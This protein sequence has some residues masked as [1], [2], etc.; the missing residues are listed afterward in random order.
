[1]AF[2]GRERELSRLADALQR[3]ADGRHGRV[4]LT[5][6]AGIGVTRLLDELTH[7]IAGVPGIVVARGAALESCAGEA[8]Q[9]LG[10]ALASALA[11]LEDDRVREVVGRAGHDLGLVLRE[12]ATRLDAL[13]IDRSPPALSAPDQIGSRVQEA[14]LGALERLAGD[15]IVL[16]ALEDLHR[17]DP[18]TRAFIRSLLRIS[19]PLP[20]CLVLTYQ[21]DELHRRHPAR[22]LARA[23]QA[24]PTIEHLAVG[25]LDSVSM[26][27]LVGSLQ[28]DR[29][30][31]DLLAAV[32][33]GSGGNPLMATQL[34]AA[35]GSLEGV[36]LSDP[37]EQVVAARIEALPGGPRRVI[38]LLG[39]ARQPIPRA[40]V[41][42]L[43][44]PD[45]R[46]TPAA[47]T[48]A[49]A[50]GMVVE[51]DGALSIAHD[52][53]AEAIED[54]EL[55]N[56]RAGVHAALALASADH[57]AR[58]AC[59]WRA[60]SRTAEARDAHLAAAD[61][62]E[63]LDPG[64]TTLLHLQRV[65][66]LSGDPALG[67]GPDLGDLL[68]RAARA[69]AATGSF[70]RAAGLMRRAVEASVVR[71][72]RPA[73]A[74][75]PDRRVAITPRA[76][77]PRDDAQRLMV[78]AMLE[79]VGRLQWAGGDL[80]GALRSMEQALSTMPAAPSRERA[81]A[82]ASLAQHLM[83]A[84]SFPESARRAEEAIEA[85]RQTGPTALA[86]L[87]HATCTLG[88]DVAYQGELA[89]G[90]AL[91]AEAAR[92]AREAG[93]LDD[94]MRAAA[95]RTTLLDLD[96]RREE[97]LAVVEEGIAE[98]E[99]GG[100]AGTFGAFLRG[101]AADI[102]Y[103]LGRWAESEAECR[104]GME[105]QPAGVA[106][107]S[108]TLY[109]GL[110]LVESRAD[111]EASSLV[112][113]TLLQLDTVPAGQW[114][115]LVQRAAV[116]LALWR[117]NLADAVRVA[118]REWPRV[119]ETEDAVQIALGASTCLEAAAAATEH[120]RAER[121]IGLVS[122][123]TELADL[124]MADAERLV[125]AGDLPP[126][127]G[128]RVEAEIHLATAGAHRARMRG[129]PSPAAWDRLA[130]AWTDR[131]MPYPAA[132]ARWWQVLALL[133]RNGPR[134]EAR[135][136]MAE[137]WR[138]AAALPA[139]PLL[140]TLSDLATRARLPLPEDPARV[141]ELLSLPES[142]PTVL[143]TGSGRRTI[144]SGGRRAVAIPVE[145]ATLL[146]AR[147]DADPDEPALP[148]PYEQATAATD[149]ITDALSVR[150]HMDE[151][152]A[153]SLGLTPR[154]MEVLRIIC[155][156]R[157]DREIS[158][159]LYIS[160]RT[161]HVHVRRV[162]SKLGVSTRTQAAALA[163]RQGIVPIAVGPAVGVP[164]GD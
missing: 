57:P 68:R 115:A 89:R 125:R 55:P 121:D 35:E 96:S 43:N 74:T 92:V 101:N 49:V 76:H 97:A 37:F 154:E 79:E 139:R 100:L 109:L 118:G 93:R 71:G 81:Q 131:R 162:L 164:A 12:G 40:T 159:R 16:L 130:R 66:E 105:W 119:L 13:A 11:T 145:R 142:R 155:E 9:A 77:G 63:R 45:G 15:G 114:S 33:E 84:G 129:R 24:D 62:S 29:P 91:L 46:I 42:G 138:L 151:S 113:Q 134:E 124:V 120:G 21:P 135:D 152:R 140:R 31:G 51:R 26:G 47:I 22:E 8:Y 56:E 34:V 88:V 25:P 146:V 14:V 136:A 41:L 112:G 50:S 102:L 106:W 90:L 5:G 94:L 122:A 158:E 117:G 111:D 6:P 4:V 72:S 39:A 98:A 28:G 44:L 59:H 27:R 143:V 36:R 7:R 32:M 153:A 107:F 132:K 137:A 18:A 20:V 128:A 149:G 86:E 156:G 95:N 85:A 150:L 17:A 30:A 144:V 157:T 110:V 83:I 87:G 52:L 48:D 38:R 123:A 53:Y 99:A 61:E 58:A 65:L 116:S 148:T 133:A 160:E 141:A 78:G 67:P 64:E 126:D 80:Q 23:L 147:P 54:H 104:A 2:V 69:T 108:P 161:V 60:A 127:V 70:R 10:V 73:S 103:Q 82:L 3:A 163:L 75:L 1:M 19:R